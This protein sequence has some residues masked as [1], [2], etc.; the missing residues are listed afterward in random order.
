MYNSFYGSYLF[1]YSKPSLIM[2]DSCHD[3]AD[4]NTFIISNRNS[5][6]ADVYGPSRLELYFFLRPIDF[7]NR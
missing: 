4:R 1:N 6:F 2:A 5:M 7:R 3:L